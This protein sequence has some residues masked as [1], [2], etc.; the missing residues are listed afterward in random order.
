MKSKE[1][2]SIIVP[3]YD[4]MKYI[5]RCL[6][7][8]IAQTYPDIEIIVVDD[9][10][11][12][13]SLEILKKYEIIDSRIKVFTK[14][15]GGVSS[16][17]NYGLKYATGNY[18]MFVDIDDYVAPTI[19]EELY[20]VIIDGFDYVVCGYEKIELNN[21][22]EVFPAKG[23]KNDGVFQNQFKLLLDRAAI[24]TPWAKLFKKELIKTNFNVLR[25]IGED[26]EFNINYLNNCKQIAWINKILYY[27][28]TTVEGSLSKKIEKSL[29]TDIELC[30]IT[31]VFM[32]NNSIIYPDFNKK[33]YE[34]FRLHLQRAFEQQYT[35]SE[36]KKLFFRLSVEGG[37]DKIA[38]TKRTKGIL[39]KMTRLS[40]C[41]N[42]PIIVYVI[43]YSKKRIFRKKDFC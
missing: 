8:L 19:C 18:V 41:C 1:I 39:N 31:E 26:F 32:Q 40:I 17:R 21:N 24:Y 20:S 38:R 29:G 7:S 9:G 27:Y 43:I 3:V 37:Y 23:Y 14:K 30:R 2:I 5:S 34:K 42:F 35:Y 12:D 10:S 22:I 4:G 15:N 36:F 13:E 28:D 16:T 33:Y 6:D 11:N 25:N